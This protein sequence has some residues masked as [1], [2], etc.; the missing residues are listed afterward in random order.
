MTFR[1]R[2]GLAYTGVGNRGVEPRR[3]TWWIKAA[4]AGDS[5]ERSHR[6]M[7]WIVRLFDFHLGPVEEMSNRELRERWRAL[8][9][10]RERN[11][12]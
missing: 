12:A 8:M 7:P 5:H 3:M 2:P 10:G 9:A 11:V 6:L 4:G 1:D